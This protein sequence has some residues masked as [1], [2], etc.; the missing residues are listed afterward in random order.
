[1]AP[2][3]V[4]LLVT[5]EKVARAAG[6][7]QVEARK[8]M[9][10][11]VRQTVANYVSLGPA[12]AF[13]GPLVRGDAE[14]VR[15]HLKALQRIPGVGDVYAALARAALR[16]LPAGNRKELQRVLSRGKRSKSL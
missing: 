15:G 11:I 8:K 1:M 3:L 12:G 9:L 10:P 2:L 7:S 14:V 16:Y 13:S 6:L 4:A 5:G